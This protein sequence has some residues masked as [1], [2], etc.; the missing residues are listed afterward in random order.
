MNLRI[1]VLAPGA[2]GAPG[3]VA[4]KLN[5]KLLWVRRPAT[6]AALR[7]AL[8]A[9]ARALPRIAATEAPSSLAQRAE[10]APRGRT[11]GRAGKRTS[12]ARGRL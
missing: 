5:R 9:A 6:K 11:R 10:P 8:D 1:E 4:I 12:G 7:R 3:F 2:N